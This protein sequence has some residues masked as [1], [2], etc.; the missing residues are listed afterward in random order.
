VTEEM[1]LRSIFSFSILI[2]VFS[3]IDGIGA[4]I[5]LL[6]RILISQFAQGLY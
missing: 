1:N 4:S 6:R 2:A 5:A 3:K